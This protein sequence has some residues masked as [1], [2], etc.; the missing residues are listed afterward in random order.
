MRNSESTLVSKGPCKHCPSSDACGLYD[1]G[2]T[3]CF[4]CGTHTSNPSKASSTKANPETEQK[5][6]PSVSKKS[7]TTPPELPKDFTP[8]KDRAISADTAKKYQ[9]TQNLGEGRTKHIYPYFDKETGDYVAAKYRSHTKSFGWKGD[10]SRIGLF[11]QQ[12]FPANSAK[13]ITIVEGECD[14][15]A[16]YQMQGSRYPVVSVT[17]AGAAPKDCLANFNYLNSFKEIVIVFDKDEGK[18]NPATGVTHYVGQE[19]AQAVAK[20]FPIGKVRI[21]TLNEYKDANDYLIE[22]KQASFMK[23][24]WSAPTYTPAGLV[25]GKDLWDKIKEPKE[26]DSIPWPWDSLNE[27]TYGIRLSEMVV[28][29]AET[30]VGKT[31]LLKESQHNILSISDDVGIGILHLEE[32]NDDTALGLIS[33]TANKP[34]H[35]PDVRAEVT[36]EQMRGWF[37]E[38]LD[39]DRV[40]MWDHF[41][42]NTIEEV[43][44]NIRFMHN[45]GCKYIFL[46]HFS[47]LVSDQN[48]DERKQLDEA[49]TKLKTLCMELDIALIGVIHQNRQGQIR[50]TA[51]VEQLA[52]IVI[53]I[54]RDKKAKDPFIR[55]V[56]VMEVEKNRFCGRTGPAGFLFYEAN[57][58]RMRELTEEEARRFEEGIP[59]EGFTYEEPP[60]EEW[61]DDPTD[62]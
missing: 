56:T 51:G 3:Y 44:A 4:S 9:V 31:S 49:A 21:V 17:S 60:T 26:N 16:A 18:R 46:D 14:A 29:T 23:E 41:G 47:I 10:T 43:I 7:T 35:L 53:K 22:G 33:I 15:M 28:V 25:V 12:L 62:E 11:G 61:K 40:V 13:A 27:K 52:N 59:Q 58:G 37:E 2:H 36:T 34:L 30:G 20:L 55:N 32:P 54:N 39:N 48:G 19:A 42:S 50:G 8:L 1:D 57:T 45:M 6:K 38:T 5:K 24:W